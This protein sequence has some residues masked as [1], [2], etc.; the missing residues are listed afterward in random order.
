MRTAIVVVVAATALAVGSTVADARPRP[1]R[2]KRFESNKTFGLGIELG[3]P[4]GI[5]GKYFLEQGGDRALDFG[6]GDNDNGYIGDRTGLHLYGDYLFHPLSLTSQESFELPFDFGVGVRYWDFDYGRDS[7]YSIGIRVPFGIA[8][9][10]NNV[11]V[12]LFFQIVPVLDFVHNYTHDIVGDV[13]VS[14]GAR[15]WFD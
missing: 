14:I 6:I 4:T 10:F 3:A 7:G 5:T 13:D 1:Q 2:G 15:F 9:D 8:F 12:D 11:P